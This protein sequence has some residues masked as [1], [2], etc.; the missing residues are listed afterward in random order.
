MQLRLVEGIDLAAYRARWGHALDAQRI[1]ALADEGLV[2]YRNYR[3]AATARGRLVL[4]SVIVA[5]AD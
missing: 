2:T 1:A 3:L 5:L 4:N